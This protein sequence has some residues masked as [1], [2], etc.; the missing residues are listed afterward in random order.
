MGNCLSCKYNESIDDEN[1]KCHATPMSIVHTNIY[2]TEECDS[3]QPAKKE[4]GTHDTANNTAS[5]KLPSFEKVKEDY[6]SYFLIQGVRVEHPAL[7]GLRYAYD[8]IARQ[9]QA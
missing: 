6:I 9:L 8:Y 7:N 3:Y 4:S 1:L 5:P 2:L